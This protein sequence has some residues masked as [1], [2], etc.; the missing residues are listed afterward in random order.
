[1]KPTGAKNPV[2][3]TREISGLTGGGWGGQ[4][5]LNVYFGLGD[6]IQID[7]IKIE[8]PSGEMSFSTDVVINQTILFTEEVANSAPVVVKAIEDTT[9]NVGDSPFMLD[10]ITIFNDPDGDDLA[11]SANSSD[12]NVARADTSGS[13]LTVS[14]VAEGNATIIVTADDGNNPAV[15]ETFEVTVNDAISVDGLPSIPTE[16]WLYQNHPNPFNPETQ[17]SYEL[18]TISKVNLVIYSL[19]G[20]RV[21]TLIDDEVPTGFH[22]II[23]NG[24]DDFGHRVPSGIYFL[25]IQA[26]GSNA[27]RFVAT[28]KLILMK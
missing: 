4:N 28:R 7:S 5:S 20:R 23:W 6:A 21:R 26:T 13:T 27:K 9:L 22:A 18:P 15:S 25:R 16:F 2:W 17:I 24:L 8:W 19:L 3:Q 12:A 1:M 14:A 11:F 10:L